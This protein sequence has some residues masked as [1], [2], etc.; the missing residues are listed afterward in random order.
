MQPDTEECNPDEVGDEQEWLV[1]YPAHQ[2]NRAPKVLLPTL[3]KFDEA[4]L[5]DRDRASCGL[6]LVRHS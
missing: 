6:V 5:H 1:G 2:R 4:P 3:D